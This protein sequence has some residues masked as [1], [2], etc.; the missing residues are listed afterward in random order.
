[1]YTIRIINKS[2]KR[3]YTGSDGGNTN[4]CDAEY[5]G[6]PNEVA[7]TELL[8]CRILK[9]HDFMEFIYIPGATMVSI[10]SDN[11]VNI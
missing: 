11:L 10:S 8:E 2:V 6:H 1:M 9:A 7:I 3:L 4:T 5:S